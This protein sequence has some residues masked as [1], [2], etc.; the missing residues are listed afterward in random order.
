MRLVSRGIPIVLA[1]ALAVGCESATSPDLDLSPQFA[2]GGGNGAVAMASGSGVRTGSVRH[3][4]FN[5]VAKKDGSMSGHFNLTFEGPGNSHHRGD[6]V[7]ARTDGN[8]AWIGTVITS[9]TNPAFTGTE[10]GFY[11]EDNGEGNGAP[12]R[13]SLTYVGGNPGLAQ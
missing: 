7:C 1:A 5:A 3:F 13:L 9:S 8:R 6:V 11:V 12:D 10:G 2:R 4:Q